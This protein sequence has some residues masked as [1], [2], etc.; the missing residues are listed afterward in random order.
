M[1]SSAAHPEPN[2][3]DRS[4]AGSMEGDKWGDG[5]REEIVVQRVA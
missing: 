5:D 3:K 2:E 4:K 1:A